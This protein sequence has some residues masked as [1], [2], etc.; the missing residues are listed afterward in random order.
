VPA[1]IV[2][3]VIVAV[4]IVAVIAGMMIAMAHATTVATARGQVLALSTMFRSAAHLR[5]AA[6]LSL[7]E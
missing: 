5:S 7:T 1:T 6:R 3:V 2:A 4:V